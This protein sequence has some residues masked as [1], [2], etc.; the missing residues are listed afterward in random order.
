MSGARLASLVLG[1]FVALLSGACER[2]K[3]PRSGPPNLIFITVD[4]L[5]ADH[6]GSYGY[7]L[8]TSPN[9]DRLAAEGVRFADATVQW[10]KTWPQMASMLTSMYPSSTGVRL[11]PRVRLPSN[12]D[13]LAEVLKGA[14]YRTAAVVANAN[15]G[16]KFAFDQG[17]DVFVES[18]AREFK[19][20]TGKDEFQNRPGLVKKYTN[21]AIVT[22]Q[23]TELIDGDLASHQPFFLW[24]HYIDPHGPYTP[25]PEYRDLFRADHPKN[26]VPL[27]A[28]PG[29]QI[30]RDEQGK[31]ISDIGFYKSQYD[32]SIRYF[33]DQLQRLLD[34]LDERGLRDDT[35]IVLTADHGESLDEDR[36]LLEHGAAPY[37]P[38]ASVPL[39]MV[40]KGKIP[41]AKV[42]E[43]PVGLI[44]V[45]P[46]LLD[47]LGVEA[48]RGFHGKS[49]R[50]ALDSS[51]A[52]ASEYV[53]MES[54]SGEPTQL[55]VRHGKW[56]LARLR[57]PKDRK[58]FGRAELEL[59]DLESDPDE[60]RNLIDQQREVAKQLKR[61]LRRWV[62]TTPRYRREERVEM[63]QL[64]PQTKDML[65]G[66]GYVD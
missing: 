1:L 33:D 35:M 52:P 16:K 13:T 55:S 21:G 15:V 34:D 41:A 25:P 66:L 23:A 56:K 4:T 36:Y 62:H 53:F 3:P 63:E 6:L 14:G 61:E 59:Y 57:A 39:L 49:L 38:T 58:T 42:V 9:L 43:S 17:F 5:R 46:T 27:E 65:R 40:L 48:P 37:Q 64:D 45:V 31:A 22:D 24:L 19:R 11:Y 29:Y 7:R 2:A 26:E 47:V 10:P 28:I 32:A 12:L 60:E 51:Q 8:D 18:W 54:G 30:Q 20:Q 44:D 50:A